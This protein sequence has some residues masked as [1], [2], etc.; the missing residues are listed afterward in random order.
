MQ[1]RLKAKQKNA[2]SYTE[3]DMLKHHRERRKAMRPVR[4]PLTAKD[5]RKRHV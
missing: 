3:R 2:Q 5:Y 4:E 1:A